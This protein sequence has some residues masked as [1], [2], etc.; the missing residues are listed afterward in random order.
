[1]PELTPMPGDNGKQKNNKRKSNKG[2]GERIIK[3]A[4]TTMEFLMTDDEVW[5]RNFLG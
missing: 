5:K 2:G 4:T 3:N 1:M